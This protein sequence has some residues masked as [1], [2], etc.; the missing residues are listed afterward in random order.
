MARPYGLYGSLPGTAER[1][2]HDKAYLATLGVVGRAEVLAWAR[3]DVSSASVTKDDAMI[4]RSFYYAIE[5]VIR[6]HVVEVRPARSVYSPAHRQHNYLRQLQP[7]YVVA[8]AEVLAWARLIW[9]S[10]VIS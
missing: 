5:R 9:R 2:I 3:F 6:W 7:G 4:H 1:S 8:G 10:T